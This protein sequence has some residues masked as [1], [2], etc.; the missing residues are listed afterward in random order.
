MR[1]QRRRRVTE[2]RPEGLAL[3]L[4]PERR[5][6]A[7]ALVKHAPEREAVGAAVHFLAADLLGRQVVERAR[8]PAARA[9]LSADPEVAEVGVPL[10]VHE[11]VRGL[12]VPVHQPAA[13][14]RIERVGDLGEQTDCDLRGQPPVP[15]EHLSQVA[16]L[17]PAH[18]EVQLPL[19]LTGLVDR[20]HAGVVERRR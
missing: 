17:D 1:A 10:V 20:D 4:A 15:L 5:R 7:E 2:V 6:T 8:H 14:S 18:G 12:H 3:G 9:S 16:P 13:V 19:S 11:D